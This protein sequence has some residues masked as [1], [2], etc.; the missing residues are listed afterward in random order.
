MR[1]TLYAIAALTTVAAAAPAS[2]TIILVDASS[3]QGDNVLFNDGVQTG[4]IVNGATQ[5]GTVV[6]F[7]GATVNG[8]TTIRA[9][10]GQARVEGAL[11]SSTQSPND[12]LGLSS[13]NFG[14]VGGNTFNN[15]EFNVFGG[16]A[17]SATFN[18]TDNEGQ[19]FTFEQALGDGSNFFG[20]KGIDGQ[21]IA[22]ASLTFN[23]AGGIGDVRQIRLDEVRASPSAVPEPATWGMMLVGF[24][25]IG[26]GLRRRRNPEDKVRLR[27]PL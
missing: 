25:A 1:P 24:A 8:G 7:T 22:N 13:L 2:A 11:D 4:P 26:A 9:N 14:L 6:Q 10:G 17:T 27:L 5:A 23:G 18:L 12:T 16:G 20:F 15:L 3:I 19:L 21:S